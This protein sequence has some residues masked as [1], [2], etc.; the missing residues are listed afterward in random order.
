MKILLFNMNLLTI[1]HQVAPL[2]QYREIIT[3]L[4]GYFGPNGLLDQVFG[5]IEVMKVNPGVHGPRNKM[6]SNYCSGEY[7]LEPNVRF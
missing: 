4:I 1:I 3:H 5:T 2:L 6:G 7:P